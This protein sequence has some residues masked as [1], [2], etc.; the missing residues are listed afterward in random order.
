MYFSFTR[1]DHKA[2][3]E[4]RGSV[5]ICFK[6]T[7]RFIRRVT[8]EPWELGVLLQPIFIQKQQELQNSPTG[9]VHERELTCRYFNIHQG[10][11]VSTNVLH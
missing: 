5:K 2:V 6:L 10:K 1:C 4:D 3:S 9:E 11:D 8:A 7:R